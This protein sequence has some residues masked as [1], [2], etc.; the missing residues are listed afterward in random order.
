[1][2]GITRQ[3]LDGVSGEIPIMRVSVNTAVPTFLHVEDE[4]TASPHSSIPAFLRAPS[5]I[6]KKV[7]HRQPPDLLSDCSEQ[8]LAFL[9]RQFFLRFVLQQEIQPDFRF[10]VRQEFIE[11]LA[12]RRGENCVDSAVTVADGAD[13]LQERE[14]GP[15]HPKTNC[16]R[17]FDGPG[18]PEGNRELF[19]GTPAQLH[20][21]FI[22]QAQRR[23]G[24]CVTPNEKAQREIGGQLY[25]VAVLMLLSP[26]S[27]HLCTR[28]EQLCTHFDELCRRSVHLCMGFDDLCTRSANLFTPFD[29]LCRCSGNLYT[30]FA[31][32][33]TLSAHLCTRSD[34]AYTLFEDACT[35]F[36]D[37]C[38]HSAESCTRSAD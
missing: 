35:C 11:R 38:A 8:H 14:N 6:S 2:N 24:F 23:R 25:K 32:L 16:F 31:D 9:P 7:F 3:H 12:I 18:F 26:F 27:A 33:C 1:M 34:D 29:D 10:P 36:D 5:W 4:D 13:A 28:T 22:S 30:R 19:T 20:P 17:P 21:R 15:Q 37:P